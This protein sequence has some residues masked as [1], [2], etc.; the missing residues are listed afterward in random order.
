MCGHETFMATHCRRHR[1]HRLSP[2]K[3]IKTTYSSQ[4]KKLESRVAIVYFLKCQIFKKNDETWEKTRNLIYTLKKCDSY[5]KQNKTTETLSRPRNQIQQG[6]K[7]K[8]AIIN[9]FKE[10]KETTP[11]EQFSDNDLTNRESQ[12]RSRH[13]KKETNGNFEL[14]YIKTENF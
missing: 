5:S 12:Q 13:Y 8:I 6:K 4:K 11:L 3:L 7:V 14:K 1:F 10:L 9:I 2:D